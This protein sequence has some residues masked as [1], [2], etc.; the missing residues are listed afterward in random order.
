MAVAKVRV[1]PNG[2]VNWILLQMVMR[3]ESEEIV[4]ELQKLA[5]SLQTLCEE[6]QERVRA[7]ESLLTDIEPIL[8]DAK[9]LQADTAPLW[10]D[11]YTLCG[12]PQCDGDCRVCQEGEEDYEDV[13]EEKY[14]R[15]RR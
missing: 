12:N 7:L 6:T 9:T 2:V 1:R 3:V 13:T 10:D 4:P 15:R 14:C 11:A 8:A 5:N